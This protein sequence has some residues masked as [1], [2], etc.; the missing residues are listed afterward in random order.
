MRGPGGADARPFNHPPQHPS[1]TGRCSCAIAPSS[2]VQATSGLAASSGSYRNSAASFR[3]EASSTRQ[4]RGLHL[5]G[6]CTR[7]YP[8]TPHDGAHRSAGSPGRLSRSAG[9]HADRVSGPASR[10]DAPWRRAKCM[11]GG[12]RA[13]ASISTTSSS[14][15]TGSAAM[16]AWGLECRRRPN[17]VGS[18]AQRSIRGRRLE[19]PDPGPPLCWITGGDLATGPGP[20]AGKPGLVERVSSCSFVG[21]E[22]A[23]ACSAD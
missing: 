4:T 14:R 18:S 13:T 16:A 19:A 11:A 15:Q 6:G 8:T 1:S 21:R 12:S 22:T 2:T 20:V 3:N 5:G 10:P 7:A 9:Q 23:N 17:S